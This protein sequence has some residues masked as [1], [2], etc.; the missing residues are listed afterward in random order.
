MTHDGRPSWLHELE[1][2]AERLLERH[3]AVAD[4]WFPHQ[5]V[6][7]SQG[8]DFDGPLRGTPWQEAQSALDPVARDGLVLSVLTEDNLPV[9]HHQLTHLIGRDG[10]WGAWLHRWTA[11]EDRHSTA[12]RSYLHTTR[13]VEPEAL[14]RARLHH[15]STPVA[16]G[17]YPEGL[18][19][20]AY[21]LIQERATRTSHQ[22]IG[23][24]SNEDVCARLMSRLAQDENLHMLFYRDLYA[25]LF[26]FQ[27]DHAMAALTATVTD[28][29]M[30]GR[31]IPGFA[32]MSTR[33]ALAGWYGPTTYLNDVLIP[34]L[35]TLRVMERT[36]LTATGERDRE[37]LAASL[38]RLR[39]QAA[40]FEQQQQERRERLSQPPRPGN[41][42]YR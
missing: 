7:W 39:T 25:A 13:A 6:P 24:H 17:D 21:V 18:R 19:G 32:T 29:H 22:S 9:Y 12:L 28:F 33:L 34:L 30:P 36:D 20:L 11:E 26:D 5:Y 41:L 31:S 4:D 14:E 1:P 27:P 3:L 35:R 15:L 40:R 10:A 16:P 42:A 2:V 37:A 23:L 8:R 38:A